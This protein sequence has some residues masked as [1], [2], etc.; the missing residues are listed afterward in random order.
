MSCLNPFVEPDLLLR[1]AVWAGLVALTVSLALSTYIALLRFRLARRLKYEN[2]CV[3][4][5]RPMLLETV[6]TMPMQLPAI[7]PRDRFV[8][9]SLWN[10]FQESLRGPAR[11]RLKAVALRQR[12][13]VAAR[14]MVERGNVRMQ[15]IGVATLGQLGDQESW[16]MLEKLALGSHAQLSLA[17]AR[18]LVQIDAARAIDVLLPV[19]AERDDWPLSRLESILT[20]ADPAV[21]TL[22]LVTTIDFTP[23][24][25]LPKLIA[26]LDS[27]DATLARPKIRELLRRTDDVDTLAACLK[28][29]HLPP[30][31]ALIERFT[32][33]ASWQV[34]TQAARAMGS[35][36]RPGDEKTLIRMLEDPVWW[37]RYRAAQALVS[38]P[39]LTREDLWRLRFV[40]TDRFAQNMLD[41]AVAERGP[42]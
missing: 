42:S 16:S 4:R 7:E 18:A 24:S 1:F 41:Q 35:A 22:P 17:A 36:A 39:F 11:H 21:T 38:L 28:S 27:A 15:F 26:L 25:R 29:R 13:D 33:H 14:N 8:F 2:R 19:L 30:E 12:M 9:L 34:R 32:A 5:W 40:V 10:Q 31:A 6:D 37:V 23:P 20:E 3:A